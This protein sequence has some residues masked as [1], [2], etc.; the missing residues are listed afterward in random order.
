MVSKTLAC[1]ILRAGAAVLHAKAVRRQLASQI[2][3]RTLPASRNGP[4]SIRVLGHL[5]DNRWRPNDAPERE[6]AHPDRQVR[7]ALSRLQREPL[8]GLHRHK[9]ITTMFRNCDLPKLETT[10][11]PTSD[12]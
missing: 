6:R 9:E 4:Q 8:P 5:D 10:S 11:P 2:P 7:W 12:H 1:R 3:S